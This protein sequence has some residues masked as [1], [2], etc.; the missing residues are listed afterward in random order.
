MKHTITL[1]MSIATLA[2]SGC[3]TTKGF[4]VV[5][6]YDAKGEKLNQVNLSAQGSGIYS[7]RNA[8]CQSYPK[9]KIVIR[10]IKTNE[11][12]KSESPYQCR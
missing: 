10:D 8:L 1:L 4:Y 6:A 7:A 9:A 11:E 2:L 3:V 12:L 5:D